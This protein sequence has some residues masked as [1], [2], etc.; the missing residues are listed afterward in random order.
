MAF[1]AGQRLTADD[2]NY[3]FNRRRR[4]Y[5]TADQ[6]VLNSAVLI[7][8][9]DMVLPVEASAAYTIDL[10]LITDANATADFKYN[11]LLPTGA[12]V[13]KHSRWGGT[14]ADTAVNSAPNRQSGDVTTYDL[15]GVAA[16]TRVASKPSAVIVTSTTAGNC[17]FQFAQ[18]TANNVNPTLLLAG[19]WME[20]VKV[21]A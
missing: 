11:F 2:L 8:S 15:S 19:S 14:A 10:Y 3:E 21:S 4:V 20:L 13:V 7:S 18:N 5:Q 17:T 6:Q 16:G 12:I 9:P 1:L